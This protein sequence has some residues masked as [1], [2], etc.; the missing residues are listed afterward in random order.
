MRVSV[1]ITARTTQRT[2]ASDFKEQKGDFAAQY[3]AP[4]N[5]SDRQIFILAAS[6]PDL[7][8]NFTTGCHPPAITEPL[9]ARL[10]DNR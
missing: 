2:F 6:E 9:T 7:G 3:L 8:N 10:S 4:G 5:Q 1:C